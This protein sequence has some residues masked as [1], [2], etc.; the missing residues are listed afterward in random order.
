VREEGL[1]IDLK[2]E[3]AKRRAKEEERQRR[4]NRKFSFAEVF[5]ALAHR[6]PQPAIPAS[7]LVEDDAGA[8]EGR[9]KMGLKELMQA[10]REANRKALPAKLQAKQ[11]QANQS[12]S[13]LSQSLQATNG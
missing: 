8:D 5:P 6:E 1:Q 12:L 10:K 11:R 4:Y 7:P 2:E 3:M 9:P 13:Q